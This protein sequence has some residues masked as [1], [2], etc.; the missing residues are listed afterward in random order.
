MNRESLALDKA[1]AEDFTPFVGTEFEL[2]CEEGG[3]TAA[4]LALDEATPGKYAQ[5]GGRHPFSLI[6]SG[7]ASPALPQ[8]MYWLSHPE[9]GILAIFIVPISADSERRRYQAVFN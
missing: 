9:L 1:T 3:Q 8:S 7:P 2:A 6:F 4:V 5:P